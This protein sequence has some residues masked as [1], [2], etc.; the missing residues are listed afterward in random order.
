VKKITFRYV[1]GYCAAI[2]LTLHH[3]TIVYKSDFHYLSKLILKILGVQI[4][5]KI[6]PFNK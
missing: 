6:G 4:Y 2:Y 1:Y 5:C 3:R